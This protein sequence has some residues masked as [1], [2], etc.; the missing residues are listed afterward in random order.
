MYSIPRIEKNIV[1]PRVA[2]AR[3]ARKMNKEELCEKLEALGIE[4]YN[5]E[6]FLLEEQERKV[7][8]Y[9]LIALAQALEVSVDWLIE[10]ED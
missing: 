5:Y 2:E 8:D 7:L 3:K 9:E 4:M 6:L 10:R 1:G